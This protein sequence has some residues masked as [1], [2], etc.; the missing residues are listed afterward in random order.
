MSVASVLV[1]NSCSNGQSISLSSAG[2]QI[3][4]DG[5]QIVRSPL[6]KDIDVSQNAS[7][8]IGTACHG[9]NVRRAFQLQA[10]FADGSNE[11]VISVAGQIQDKLK[12]LGYSIDASLGV[13]Y[14]T[15][16]VI[17]IMR[18]SD[19]K[20]NLTILVQRN[21]PNVMLNITTDCLAP[22]H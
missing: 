20:A 2:R 6:L 13:A 5:G 4:S 8:D 11:S 19:K 3:A 15:T 17:T 16:Q 18:N 22:A 10:Q 21:Q 7:N 1:L 9:D 14:A 12:S